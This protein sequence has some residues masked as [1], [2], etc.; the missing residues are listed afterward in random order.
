MFF[1]G[2]TPPALPVVGRFST[3][4]ECKCGTFSRRDCLP[5]AEGGCLEI[6]YENCKCGQFKRCERGS[7]YCRRHI[8]THNHEQKDF[9]LKTYITYF[10]KDK[11]EIKDTDF[12]LMLYAKSIFLLTSQV[13]ATDDKPDERDSKVILDALADY[14]DLGDCPL[15]TKLIK[16]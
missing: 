7:Y 4:V 3:F 5:C 2:L 1:R 14:S 6:G 9:N 12:Y 15:L 8:N 11:P 13:L 16:K 10:K